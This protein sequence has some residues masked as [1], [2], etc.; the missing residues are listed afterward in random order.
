MIRV[1]VNCFQSSD[2]WEAV[3]PGNSGTLGPYETFGELVERVTDITFNTNYSEHL[4][5]YVVADNQAPIVVLKPGC[6]TI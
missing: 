3:I 2:G 4:S 1:D 5:V 6:G